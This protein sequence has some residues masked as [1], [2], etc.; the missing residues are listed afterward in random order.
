MDH[1]FLCAGVRLPGGDNGDGRR[2]GSVSQDVAITSSL[3]GRW[4]RFKIRG[5]PEEAFS[6]ANG[7]LHLWERFHRL[8]VAD[9]P[10]SEENPGREL[11]SAIVHFIVNNAGDRT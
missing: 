7:D 1:A 4:Y 5:L 10:R 8:Y 3:P 2:A 6:T 9:R 11:A